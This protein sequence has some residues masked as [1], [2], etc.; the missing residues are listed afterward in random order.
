MVR[1]YPDRVDSKREAM[2]GQAVK[3]VSNKLLEGGAAKKGRKERGGEES[4]I[5]PSSDGLLGLL[6]DDEE[7]RG[8]G[9]G[10][11]LAVDT[12]GRYVEGR[13]SRKGEDEDDWD[14]VIRSS[15]SREEREDVEARC[16]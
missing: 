9:I 16:C 11:G 14:R 3:L 15:S 2:R 4:G 7:R 8:R 13:N 5:S 1:M 10:M 12:T 6:E